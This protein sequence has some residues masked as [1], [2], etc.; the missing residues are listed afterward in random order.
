VAPALVSGSRKAVCLLGLR[1]APEPI[2]CVLRPV[3]VAPD[4][5][6]LTEAQSPRQLT[7]VARWLVAYVAHGVWFHTRTMESAFSVPQP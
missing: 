7:T 4:N 2:W 5:R 1:D 3:L 6:L